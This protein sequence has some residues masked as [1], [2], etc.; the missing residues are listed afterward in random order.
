MIPPACCIYQSPDYDFDRNFGILSGLLAAR[1]AAIDDVLRRWIARHP[2]GIVVSLGEGLETQR[3]RVDNGRVRWISVDLPG[4][5]L[6][7]ER[8]LAPT[9]RFR[10][11]ATSAL[12]PAWMDAVDPMA[13]VFISPRA[14]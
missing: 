3:Y 12:D 11:V 2:D 7:R 14:Y 9:D 5:T 13:A 8:F 1:G 10:H 6:L 4:A